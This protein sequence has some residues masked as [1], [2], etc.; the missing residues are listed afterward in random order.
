MGVSAATATAIA[1]GV[2]ATAALG[3]AVMSSSAQSK[4]ADAIAAQNQATEEA[5]NT[6]FFQ[7]NQAAS[8]QT[9]AQLAVMTQTMAD[10]STAA[11]QARQAQMSAQQQQESVLN[12][13]NAQEQA[14]HQTGVNDAQ[15]LLTQTNA[16]ALAAAQQAS[17]AQAALLLNQAAPQ[18]PAPTDPTG[19]SGDT[20]TQSA[21]QRRLAEAAANVRSYGSKVA[22]VQSYN[23][24]IADVSTAIG[25]NQYG[26][27][28]AAAADTLL[29]SGSNTLLLPSQVAYQN[30]GDL[31]QALDQ[32]IQSR[33]QG[34][35]NTAAL[36]YGNAVD[37][38]NLGQSDADTLA[39]NQAA[40]AK[41]D[42]AAQQSLGGLITSVGNLGLYGAG[43]YGAHPGFLSPASG[44]QFNLG[45]ATPA[46]I[47]QPTIT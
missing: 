39:S 38:A 27:M 22:A 41:A 47:A 18:G 42:A 33:G 19:A 32:L 46:Q 8:A 4:A 11:T 37:Q 36:T 24:P 20:T 13:E 6:A 40:Q 25:E 21:V 5:Q 1:A 7:R 2:S 12:T 35:M 43:Y 14:L 30:S 34:A 16:P 15:T 31:G 26:I 10:R 29:R 9:A 3:G 23:Q 44:P 45:P 17:Q 28:P